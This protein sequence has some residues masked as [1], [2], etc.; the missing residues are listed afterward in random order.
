MS[1]SCTSTHIY[2]LQKC[3]SRAYMKETPPNLEERI[4][5][6][7]QS[8]SVLGDCTIATKMDWI[9]CCYCQVHNLVNGLDGDRHEIYRSEHSCIWTER[10]QKACS[11]ITTQKTQENMLVSPK[12]TKE[13][14]KWRRKGKRWKKRKKKQGVSTSWVMVQSLSIFFLRTFDCIY[15]LFIFIDDLQWS[16]LTLTIL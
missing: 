4:D 5:T 9:F 6:G 7:F 14:M 16:F 8:I 15:L 12:L 3:L 13:E 11:W 1:L 2:T 10:A